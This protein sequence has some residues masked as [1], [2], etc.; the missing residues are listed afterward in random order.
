MIM[1]FVAEIAIEY[2]LEEAI[3]LNNFIYWINHNRANGTNLYDG[4]HW[5]YNTQ[6][7]F[8]E[9]FPFLSQKVIRRALS[10]LIRENVI[11]TGNYNNSGYNR[12][13]WYALVKE[14]YWC[15]INPATSAIRPNGKM[16]YPKKANAIVE[17]DE[18]SIT[19]ELPLN[20]KEKK[21]KTVSYDVLNLTYIEFFKKRY[22]I[23]PIIMYGKVNGM[24][25]KLLA[26]LSL[27][28]LN[29]AVKKYLSDNEYWLI[30]NKHPIMSIQN[31]INKYIDKKNISSDNK[32]KPLTSEEAERAL[33]KT[34]AEIDAEFYAA[35]EKRNARL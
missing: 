3:L 12:T 18:S 34:R 26:I 10:T 29:N 33:Y 27:D 16:E 5:T 35:Q 1:S 21:E 23:E 13:T 7:A 20:G 31:K 11:K 8:Q 9:L 22:G 15:S 28:Q 4:F 2:G 14:E 25:K 32:R 30:E 17:K 24:W 6:K 19:K